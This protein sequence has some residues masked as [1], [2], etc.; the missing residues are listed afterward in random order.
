MNHGGLL[1][2]HHN[3]LINHTSQF[4]LQYLNGALMR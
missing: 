1:I 3:V 2:D 4:Y